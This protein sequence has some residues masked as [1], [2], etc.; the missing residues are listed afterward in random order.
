M[1]EKIKKRSISEEPGNYSKQ[2]YIAG[3]KENP[4]QMDQRTRK[5]M[6]MHKDLHPIDRLYV[7]RKEGGRGY[8]T[9]E[10]SVVV[11]IQRLEDC[12]EKHGWILI[13]ATRN[14]IDDTRIN[15]TK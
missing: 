1:K 10:D 12:I 2:N 6:T 5:L 11:S 3:T 8:V 15:R 14:N 4:N 13:T 9:M 7:S